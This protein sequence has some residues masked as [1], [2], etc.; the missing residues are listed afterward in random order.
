V[1]ILVAGLVFACAPPGAMGPSAPRPAP[2]FSLQDVEGKTVRLSD[3]AGRVRLV[4][5]WAT[6]CP[7]CRE[8]I[9]ELKDLHK[10][11]GEKGLTILAISMDDDAKKVLPPFLEKWEVPYTNLIGNDE[12][13]ESF[14]G[15][16]GLP[17]TFLV[18]KEGQIVSTWIGGTPKEEIEKKV[19]QALGLDSAG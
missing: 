12:V 14:G 11:Y 18:D 3:S 2:D 15:V 9:P 5:F 6:W 10:T 1:A 13:A 16:L 19:R 8:A 17:T 7:P 4:D